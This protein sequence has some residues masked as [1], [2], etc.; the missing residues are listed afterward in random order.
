LFEAKYMLENKQRIPRASVNMT[1]YNDLRFID[2]AVMS[3]LRQTYDD[4]ELIIVVDGT[5]QPK[6]FSRLA[7]L[8][9]RVRIVTCE[10]NIGTAAAPNRTASHARSHCSIPI[11]ASASSAVGRDQ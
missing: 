2:A 5:G 8:D 4:F 7:A 6:I 9:T 10:Q 1:A 11:P 3:L